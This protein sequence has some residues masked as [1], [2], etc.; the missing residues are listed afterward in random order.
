M[1]RPRLLRRAL[2]TAVLALAVPASAA[3]AAAQVRWDN[4]VR[5][6]YEIDDN[7]REE[8]SDALRARVAR[9]SVQSDLVLDDS[10]TN[11]LS[12][13][14]QG[15]FKRYFDVSGG[16]SPELANQFLHEGEVA[17]R[18]LVGRG[19][20]QLTGG[21]KVRAWADDTFFLVN[22]DGYTRLWGGLSASH[23]LAPD[24]SGEV[25]VRASGIEFDHVDEVFGYEA[26]SARIGLVR[27]L[28]ATAQADVGLLV[29]QRTYDGRGKLRNADDDPSNIFAEDRPRQID[30]AHDAAVG[31]SFLAPFGFQAR[32]RWHRNESNSFGFD[33]TSHIWNVQLAQRLPWRMIAQVYGAVELREFDEPV[34]GL[35]GALDVEDTDNNVLILRLLKE[36]N[37]HVD[38]EARYG[39]Y[40][41]ES[42]NLDAFYTKNVYSLGFRFR[43]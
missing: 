19:V 18:R 8:V 3:P 37:G 43:T 2:G 33:Y 32:Y 36:L 39:R 9:V 1:N 20:V 40:R 30:L 29:E 7:V 13:A 31:F 16:E 28:G 26:Q 25:A 5:V 11:Q 22:E 14:Y 41:N 6:S 42:I 35:V 27:R 34:R 10:T 24:W 23:P 21:V 17:Y 12:L 38:V 15:G 4:D